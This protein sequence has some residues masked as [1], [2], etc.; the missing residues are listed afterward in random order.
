VVAAVAGD[1]MA[2]KPGPAIG[3]AGALVT[4]TREIGRWVQVRQYRVTSIGASFS[5]ALLL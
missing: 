3:V 2:E 1:E 5:A 4:S